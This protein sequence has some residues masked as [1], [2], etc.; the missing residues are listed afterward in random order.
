VSAPSSRVHLPV[1]FG[2]VAL[3]CSLTTTAC[4]ARH[5][6]R[7][8][9]RSG[10]TSAKFATCA[11]CALGAHHAGVELPA[12]PPPPPEKPAA[13]VCE[14]CHLHRAAKPFH[15]STNATP[16]EQYGWCGRCRLRARVDARNAVVRAPKA[17]AA[18]ATCDRCHERPAGRV[19]AS[20]AP[21]TRAWCQVC[22]RDARRARSKGATLEP[23]TCSKCHER[24]AAR[25]VPSTR[26]GREG[27]CSTCRETACTA[28][29]KRRV[30]ILP[31][32][33]STVETPCERCHERP[34][35]IV[36]PDTAPAFQ[37]WCP[38]CRD[39]VRDGGPLARP[40][41]PR[42]EA[43]PLTLGAFEA[44]FAPR[45]V[46][47]AVPRG[48]LVLAIAPRRVICANDPCAV[49][50]CTHPVGVAYTKRKDLRELCYGHRASVRTAE[51]A[52]RRAGVA[53]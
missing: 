1:L 45:F 2:C 37:A 48:G 3:R 44:L 8:E 30:G 34:V 4:G 17:C 23:T 5:L 51:H 33:P 47:D 20:T 7:G 19:L 53:A 24:P 38:P 28:E 35:G 36:R 10:H 50:G 41:P 9:A 42:P 29:Y 52:A 6:A 39:E 43:A 15:G 49:R 21:E 14:R 40:M 12:P 26:K 11:G 46:A 18:R 27:W 25:V 32:V 16:R 13:K 22:R 31:E